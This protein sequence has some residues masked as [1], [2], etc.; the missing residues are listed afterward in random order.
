MGAARGPTHGD[1][2]AAGEARHTPGSRRR[3]DRARLEDTRSRARLAL[4]H[5]PVYS[6]PGGLPWPL[7]RAF[8]DLEGEEAA[9]RGQTRRCRAHL[10]GRGSRTRRADA[11]GQ[12]RPA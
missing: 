5:A 2:G 10:M 6:T 7:A 1:D 9:T 3:E 12:P 4:L 11:A 8:P